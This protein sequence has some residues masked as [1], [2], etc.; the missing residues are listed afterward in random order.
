M[1][2]YFDKTKTR[3]GRKLAMVNS[4]L[5][6]M[7]LGIDADVEYFVCA[8]EDEAVVACGGLAGNTLKSI[9]VSPQY[10]GEGVSTRLLTELVTHAYDLG[11]Y[12]LFIYTK[13]ENYRMFHQAGFHLITSVKDRVILLE[14]SRSRLKKYCSKLRTLKRAGDKVGSIVMNANPFTKGHRY[15]VEHA[16]GQCDWL[17]LFVVKEDSSFFTYQ[18][19]INMIRAGV[20]DLGNVIVHDGSDYIISR[21]TFPSY[22]LKDDGVV[23]YCH[24]A[25]DLQLFR[26]YIGPALGITHRFVGTEP[27]CTVTRFYN[28]QMQTWLTTQSLDSDP[29][30]LI[31]IPR[32]EIEEQPISASLVRHLLFNNEW[33]E[34]KK[35]VPDSSYQ[36]LKTL[37]NT[38]DS[39]YQHRKRDYTAKPEIAMAAMPMLSAAV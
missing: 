5:N 26:S 15:L 38:E 1:A 35:L 31:E 13:P 39:I 30:T 23:N 11:R 32:A 4:F 36:Y 3:A 19:R 7:G 20:E 33:D 24:T 9:A 29:I 34:I 2:I 16:A 12:N 37:F 17:H 18:D 21:A 14:N 25:V 6:S 27:I 28:Q 8:I 22:F 10:Q